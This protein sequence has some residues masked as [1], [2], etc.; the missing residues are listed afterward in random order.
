MWKKKISSYLMIGMFIFFIG[1]Y[2]I[3]FVQTKDS[4]STENE[5]RKLST[6][7]EF[8]IGNYDK[9][10][11]EFTSFLKDYIPYRQKVTELYSDIMVNKFGI[12]SDE[13]VIIGKNGWL[14]YDSNKKDADTDE[15]SDYNGI[16]E[17]TEEEM[18]KVAE[19]VRRADDFCREHGAQM[20]F[21]IAP[22]K[23]SVYREYMPD[24]YFWEE[25]SRVDELYEYLCANTEAM[26]LYPKQELQEWAK[27]YKIYYANDTHWN[28]L[29]GYLTASMIAEKL[30][31]EY[32]AM[33]EIE[34]IE[35][36][37]PEDLKY[38]LGV[39][40]YVADDGN[41]IPDY[42]KRHEVKL[43][44]SWE[45]MDSYESDNQNGQRMLI[46]GD[47]FSEKLIPAFSGEVQWLDASRS[48]Y[49]QFTEVNSYDY[50]VYE[51]VERNLAII[52]K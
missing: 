3:F 25:R 24:Y 33:Q 17:Y 27:K 40:N 29:G 46:L 49:Y 14:F 43:I 16:A 41:L 1:Y 11:V 19:E 31:M 21:V 48:R 13:S 26:A 32:P 7:P 47:S 9:F 4:A 18:E 22:N 51:L 52:A 10:A 12:S 23:S 8:S 50:V 2:A 38:M 6:M 30:G 42:A 39:N 44:D 20:I 37:S 36:N 34:L 35:E 15:I 28:G 45:S 5:N